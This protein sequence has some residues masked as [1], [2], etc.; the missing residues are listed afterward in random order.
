MRSLARL[1]KGP[2]GGVCWV[3]DA[4]EPAE[5]ARRAREAGRPFARVD[6]ARVG[7][8]DALLSALAEGLRLPD[9]FGHNWDALEECLG[10]LEWLE[11]AGALVLLDGAGTLAAEAPEDLA[12]ALAILG[13]AAERWAEDG[14][15]LVV[16][17]RGC[18]R[19]RGV[20]QAR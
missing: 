3:E 7:G 4:L 14:L 18:E 1:L 11:G 12:A 10:D 6:L 20:P 15:P 5:L 13:D 19:P 16:L 2:K 17:L 8:K 9:Y